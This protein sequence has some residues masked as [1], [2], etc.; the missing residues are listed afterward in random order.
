MRSDY[1]LAFGISCCDV[2]QEVVWK[3]KDLDLLKDVLWLIS[4]TECL[5]KELSE[6]FQLEKSYI[7]SNFIGDSGGYAIR[8]STFLP[9]EVPPSLISKCYQLNA[10][11]FGISPDAPIGLIPFEDM[12]DLNK[13]RFEEFYSLENNHNIPIFDCI[14]GPI[15]NDNSS[16]TLD[17]RWEWVN[18]LKTLRGK[19]SEGYA[20][21]PSLDLPDAV[22]FYLQ[23]WSI[24]A[25]KLHLLGK[26]DIQGIPLYM[27]LAK[28]AGLNVTIDAKTYTIDAIKFL[29]FMIPDENGVP[30]GINIGRKKFHKLEAKKLECPCPVCLHFQDQF[31][32]SIYSLAEEN[33]HDRSLDGSRLLHTWMVCHNIVILQQYQNKLKSFL[34]Q[35]RNIFMKYLHKGN[36][37]KLSR[38]FV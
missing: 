7:S 31:R 21:S 18:M 35:S 32:I 6:Y 11:S 10:F 9:N 16:Y 3:L 23:P 4:S 5:E 12:L 26:G 8:V 13:V 2:F 19:Y 20:V 15:E 37:T 38:P 29:R 1:I 27:Y 33:F 22:F 34:Y 24:G 25:K 17:F 28:K 30:I 14:H 36:S